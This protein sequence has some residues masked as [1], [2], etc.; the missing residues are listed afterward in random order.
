M[1]TRYVKLAG[2][3]DFESE[4]KRVFLLPAGSSAK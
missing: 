2:R 4:F 1:E 3:A